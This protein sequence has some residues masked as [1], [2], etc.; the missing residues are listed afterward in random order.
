MRRVV[1]T[2]MGTITPIGNDVDSFWESLVNGKNGIGKLT[3]FD[4]SDF[5]VKLAAEVKDFDPALYMEA[6]DILKK[7][8]DGD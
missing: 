4:T 2:G 5:K 8:L 1:V 6:Q 7:Y 3:R